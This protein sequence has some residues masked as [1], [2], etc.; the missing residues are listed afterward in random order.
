MII[1]DKETDFTC[2]L[3]EMIGVCFFFFQFFIKCLG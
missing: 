3:A 2:K 1:T